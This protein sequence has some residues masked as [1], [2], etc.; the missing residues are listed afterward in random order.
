MKSFAAL[1]FVSQCVL[2]RFIHFVNLSY[3]I[4]IYCL[5]ISFFILQ[6]FMW[7][8]LNLFLVSYAKI[9]LDVQLE[10]ELL[11]HRV[12]ASSMSD[13]HHLTLP[14]CFSVFIPIYKS[15]YFISSLTLGIVRL[16]HFHPCGGYELI[17]YSDFKFAYFGAKCD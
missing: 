3:C 17:Y 14:S 13:V 8:L 5:D 16:L 4:I 12:C 2:R 11:S 10:I 7:T 15:C 1:F 6:T 9:S